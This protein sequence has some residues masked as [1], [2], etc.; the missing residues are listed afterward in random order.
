VHEAESESLSATP[1][2][3]VCVCWCWCQARAPSQWSR[4]PLC[5]RGTASSTG[6]GCEPWVAAIRSSAGTCWVCREPCSPISC[7]QS[8][9]SQSRSV[10]HTVYNI[11][12]SVNVSSIGWPTPL[13]LRLFSSFCSSCVYSDPSGYL[14]SHGHLTRAVCCRL[15]RDGEAFTQSLPQP[16]RLNHPEVMSHGTIEVILKIIINWAAYIPSCSAQL[17]LYSF[18]FA[19]SVN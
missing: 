1:V 16:F 18:N 17:L 19:S 7:I 12:M 8:T 15:S 10:K 14:Y 9:W 11:F 6:R 2:T 13:T 5:P 3:V 4:V